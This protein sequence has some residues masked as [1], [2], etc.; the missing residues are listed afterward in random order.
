[1]HTTI[2]S[3]VKYY[4]DFQTMH[5]G[6]LTYVQYFN[7]KNREKCAQKKKHK[8]NVINCINRTKI[9]SNRRPGTEK[10]V[11]R[12]KTHEDH[13]NDIHEN[14]IINKIHADCRAENCC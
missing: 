14:K 13:K 4:F 2:E 7:V 3:D 6:Q 5:C 8:N 11:N 10:K 12:V 1:M 9:F